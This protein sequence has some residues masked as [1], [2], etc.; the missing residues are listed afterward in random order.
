MLSK[1]LVYTENKQKI[2]NFSNNPGTKL[3]MT[4]N[5]LLSCQK[6]LW[7]NFS[8]F[9]FNHNEDICVSHVS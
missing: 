5:L 4:Y 6:D 9:I 8:F 1:T 7:F 2:T 3:A